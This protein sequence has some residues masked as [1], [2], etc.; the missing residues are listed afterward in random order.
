MSIQRIFYITPY[1]VVIYRLQGGAWHQDARF[2]SGPESIQPLDEYLAAGKELL[3]CLYTDLIE[4]EYR[5]ES[6]PHLSL[7]DRKALVQR[8]LRQQFRSTPFRAAHA[9]GRE[10]RQKNKRGRR[11]DKVLFTAL[12]NPNNLIFWLDR[13][14]VHKVPVVGIYSLP[15]ISQCL[16]HKLHLKSEHTLL[17]TQQQGSLLRQSFFNN[18]DLKASRLIPISTHDHDERITIQLREVQKDQRYLKRMHLLPHDAQLNVCILT[19]GKEINHLQERCLDD[20]NT[21][22]QFIDINH[23]TDK[24]GLQGE[25]AAEQSEELFLHLLHE[26]LSCINYARPADRRYH[27]MRQLRKGMLATSLLFTLFSAGISLNNLQSVE[28]LNVEQHLSADKLQQLERDYQQAQEA[29]PK[30]LIEPLDMQAAVT[31]HSKLKKSRFDP[32][33]LLVALSKGVDSNPR[34]QLE[35]LEWHAS[36]RYKEKSVTPT[37]PLAIDAMDSPMDTSYMA[38]KRDSSEL[39]QIATLKGYLEPVGENYHANFKL[40]EAFINSLRQTHFFINVSPTKMPL[41]TDPSVELSGEYNRD[42]GS[43]DATF[44]IRAVMRVS[45]DAV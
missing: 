15:M 16:L 19:N 2:P 14:A 25:M 45:R 10:K 24:L 7:R 38:D 20:A 13:L 28:R 3:S 22:Y 36:D 8:K 9:Q 29:L 27:R 21:R 37:A 6:I 4:E 18:F 11:D 34:I 39:Y 40:V 32:K 1:E 42:K 35:A 5:I 43:P 30:V 17:L 12:T 23:V 26:H 41:N 33:S 31:A 44:E